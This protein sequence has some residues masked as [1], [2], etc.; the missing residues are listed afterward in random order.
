MPGPS[1]TRADVST[2]PLPELTPQATEFLQ[3]ILA[4][5]A[6][7]AQAFQPTSALQRQVGQTF[8]QMIRPSGT[9]GAI[10]EAALPLFQRNLQFGA[11]VLR[12][13]GP[14]FA[15]STEQQVGQLTERSLQ[16]FNLFAQQARQFEEQRQLQTLGQAAQFDVQN[17]A[18][19]LQ[20][21]LPFLQAGLTAGGA[22]SP[23]II[24]QRQGFLQGT[25]LPLLAT[26]GT[27]AATAFG[28]PA[29]GAAVG[30]GANSILGAGGVTDVTFPTF[31]ESFRL[32]PQGFGFRGG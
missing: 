14:R 23:P 13:S 3:A 32:E 30:A 21:L 4:N 2:A 9:P 26:G 10:A 22:T 20:S 27:I 19:I 5:P 25:L 16:D 6:Q 18:Q 31:G 8:S 29:A 15:R 17:R 24:E 7:A 28:G 1:T 12:Q 11:D